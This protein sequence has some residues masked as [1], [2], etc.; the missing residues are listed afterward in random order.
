MDAKFRDRLGSVIMLAFVAVLWMNRGYTTPF[1][2]IFPDAVMI[3]MTILIALSLIRSF[4]SRH[5]VQVEN[6]QL[7]G[8]KEEKH[9][10]DMA[11]VMV[12]LLLW[13]LL[14]RYLGFAVAGVVG[15]ASIAWYISGKRKDWK[16]VVKAVL[17]GMAVTFVLMAIF[18]YLLQVPLPEGEIFD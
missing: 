6:H 1:G 16:M 12:I 11:V 17:V 14:F 2:G 5:A 4:T 10:L 9:W 13:V 7:E 18:G 3:L 8:E 15:F